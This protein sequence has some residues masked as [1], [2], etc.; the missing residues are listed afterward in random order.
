VPPGLPPVIADAEALERVV[1]NLLDNALKHGGRRV[2]LVAEHGGRE[3]AS[4]P[5]IS[6]T[7]A[8][9]GAGLTESE[10]GVVF[11]PYVRGARARASGTPGAGLGLHLVRRL[12][13]A[14][15]GT[16]ALLPAAAPGVPAEATG[17][18]FRVTLPV[19][20]PAEEAT[21]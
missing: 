14:M 18:A 11:E 3:A 10:R 19:A 1:G 16:V 13:E 12:V 6:V 5:R 17:A 9:D 7:V 2:W 8:D 15:G 20:A 4:S 21:P